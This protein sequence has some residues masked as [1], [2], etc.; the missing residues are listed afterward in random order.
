[1][2]HNNTIWDKYL[3]KINDRISNRKL[4]E[5]KITPGESIRDFVISAGIKAYQKRAY[6]L[7]NNI[8]MVAHVAE[9]V[10]TIVDGGTVLGR[11]TESAGD[12][13][14]ILYKTSKNVTRSDTVC[15]GLCVIL[16]TCESVALWCLIIK[17]IPFR[18]R[19]YVEAKIISK[20][21]MTFQNA[22]AGEVFLFS[23]SN[24]V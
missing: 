10:E 4:S 1:M 6:I 24:A 14:K 16:G 15:T 19:I 9:K 17:I 3:N 21:C 8:D 22:C 2:R 7:G 12:L 18:G 23:S 20:G 11:R 5:L 13:G